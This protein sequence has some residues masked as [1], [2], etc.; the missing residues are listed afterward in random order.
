MI[1]K[2]FCKVNSNE[3]V[4]FKVN[5]EFKYEKFR[6]FITFYK[7]LRTR[8]RS[9]SRVKK[10]LAPAPT[11]AKKLLLHRLQLRL[12]NT[13]IRTKIVRLCNTVYSKRS[14]GFLMYNYFLSECYVVF[15]FVLFTVVSSQ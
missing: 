14:L 3:I 12:R 6:V 8:L 7:N 2:R 15:I 13:R 10:T 1:I 4:I 11:P 9:R 5:F